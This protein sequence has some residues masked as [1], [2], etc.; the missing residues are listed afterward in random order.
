MV[1]AAPRLPRRGSRRAEGLFS[2]GEAD[3]AG[4]REQRRLRLRRPGYTISARRGE[5]PARRARATTGWGRGT[6]PRRRA[7]PRRPPPPPPASPPPPRRASSAASDGSR[8]GRAPV[9]PS[10]RPPARRSRG[11]SERAAVTAA[12]EAVRNRQLLQ[13][14]EESRARRG[15]PGAGRRRSTQAPPSSRRPRRSRF[16][17]SPPPPSRGEGRCARGGCGAAAEARRRGGHGPLLPPTRLRAPRGRR[18]ARRPL[19]P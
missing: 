5:A 16:A 3:A 6:G 19:C 7:G 18:G 17:R 4:T 13:P 10:V 14:R 12:A 1:P 11:R 15:A 8:R 9:R 2:G